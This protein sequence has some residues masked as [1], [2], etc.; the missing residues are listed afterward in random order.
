[1]QKQN[2]KEEGK[3]EGKPDRIYRSR[4]AGKYGQEKKT[5]KKMPQMIKVYVNTKD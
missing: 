1:M 3:Q 4:R 5:P 2:Y